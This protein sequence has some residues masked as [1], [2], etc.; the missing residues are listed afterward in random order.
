MKEKMKKV[1]EKTKLMMDKAKKNKGILITSGVLL[2]SL[3]TLIVGAAVKKKSDKDSKSNS[4]DSE[5]KKEV[6]KLDKEIESL[7]QLQ[8]DLQQIIDED[9]PDV[10]MDSINESIDGLSD[11]EKSILLYFLNGHLS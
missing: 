10:I 11:D 3:A 9:I 7:T 6:E 8:N 1:I 2:T 4:D 5:Y